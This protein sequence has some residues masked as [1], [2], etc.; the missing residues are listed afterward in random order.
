MS[1]IIKNGSVKY[2]SIIISILYVHVF[3]YCLF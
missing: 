3:I 2:I 1:I